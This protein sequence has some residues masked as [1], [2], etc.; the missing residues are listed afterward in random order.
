MKDEILNYVSMQDVLDKY[1]IE[2]RN[3]MFSCPFHGIDK[4]PSA[5][6]YKNSFY[7]FSCNQTGD[8]IEFVE[9]LFNLSFK[10]AMQKINIDFN[11]GLENNNVDYER[12]KQLK[13]IENE[14]KKKRQKLTKQYCKLCDDKLKLEKAIDLLNKKININNWETI[15]SLTTQYDMQLFYTKQDLED[16]D[17]KLSSRI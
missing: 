5:K 15:V 11:L 10:E 12:L 13:S 3:Y 1:G 7:C 4:K 2:T 17:N 14:K 8:I 9:K 6:A 16:I